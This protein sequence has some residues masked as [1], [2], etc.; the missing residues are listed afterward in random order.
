L[1]ARSQTQAEAF[2]HNFRK[3][4]SMF[5][6]LAAVGQGNEH[7]VAWCVLGAMFLW[8]F[9]MMTFRTDDWLRLVKDEQERKAKRQ[10]RMDS[11]LKRAAS[12][13][14]WWLKK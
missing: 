12:A 8:M 9:Y 4:I 3:G 13:A 2:R 10:A 5:T 7:F 11:L 14:Q 6:T 1:K